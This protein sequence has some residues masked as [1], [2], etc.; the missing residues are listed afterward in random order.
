DLE[1]L[2][3]ALGIAE[4]TV[5]GCAIGAMTA[6]S[7]AA[8]HPERMRALVLTNPTPRTLPSA[9]TML[10]ERAELVGRDGMQAILPGAVER[11]FLNL[12]QDA[13]YADYMNRFS[14][15]DAGAYALALLAA[16]EDDAEDALRALRCP[17][18][19]VPGRHDVLLPMANAEA[20][21]ALVP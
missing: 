12:P 11:A 19:L 6:A 15:Q 3:A 18:L 4:L 17:T 8:A 5:I 13:R 14:K 10:T 9:K 7:Y 20:V 1:T 21:A 16:A 2:R